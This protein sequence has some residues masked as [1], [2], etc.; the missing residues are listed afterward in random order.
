MSFLFDLLRLLAGALGGSL[1]YVAA[2]TY[3]STDKSIQNWL[4]EMWL[5]LAD[6]RRTLGGVVRG[7]A[8]VVLNLMDTL[9]DQVFGASQVSIRT[10]SVALCYAYGA[11]LLTFVPLSLYATLAQ[12]DLPDVVRE[13]GRLHLI[14]AT[15]AFVIGTL[16]A[17]RASLR[18]VTYLASFCILTSLALSA[19]VL[20]TDRPEVKAA[21]GSAIEDPAGTLIG[22]LVALTY[23]IAVVHAARYGVHRCVT[24]EATWRDAVLVGSVLL[25]PVI[26]FVA[27]A[28]VG[29]IVRRP[30]G[31]LTLWLASLL[32]RNGVKYVLFILGGPMSLW[33]IGLVISLAL[34]L[35]ALFHVIMWPVIRFVLMK[36]VYAAQRYELVTRKGRLW[37]IGLAL[38]LS[39]TA[40][41]E[42]MKL[43]TMI[44]SAVR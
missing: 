38:M 30:R 17:V 5:R 40:P 18:W 26:A 25:I 37:S 10:L 21:I 44:V 9:F 8:R 24:S 6:D 3:E 4:E 35:V 33:G 19:W 20:T 16:P 13:W 43:V 2:F 31:Q 29:V 34:L 23:G 32:Q 22:L 11:L 41:R 12:V 14:L 1:V 7:L 39:S 28:S 42:L 27:L 15:V 36:S